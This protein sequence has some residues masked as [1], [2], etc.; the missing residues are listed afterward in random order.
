MGWVF[1]V[2]QIVLLFIVP[3]YSLL[4]GLAL[5]LAVVHLF[6]AADPVAVVGSFEAVGVCLAIRKLARRIRRRREAKEEARRL[7]EQSLKQ[8]EERKRQQER[9]REIE[10]AARKDFAEAVF[11]GRYPSEQVLA[12]LADCDREIPA[13]PKEA[14]EEMLYGSCSLHPMTFGHAVSLIQQRQRIER[15]AKRRQ[16]RRRRQGD[17]EA[18]G[19]V[20]EAEAYE[21]LSGTPACTPEELT[22]AYHRKVSEWHPDKLETMA[23]ELRD[24]ATRHLARVNEAYERLKTSAVEAR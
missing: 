3:A 21:L 10:Q 19:P 6:P 8:A 12:T 18:T 5:L 7:Q 24:Y 23:Q 2:L 11:D 9:Q 4:G 13:D 1:L 20:T 14:L 16:A 15:R 17:F 22:R